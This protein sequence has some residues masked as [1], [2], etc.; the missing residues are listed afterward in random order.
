MTTKLAVLINFICTILHIFMF[1]QIIKTSSYDLADSSLHNLPCSVCVLDHCLDDM[2]Y[3][4]NLVVHFLPVLYSTWKLVRMN[5]EHSSTYVY[6][7]CF[8][9]QSP[10]LRNIHFYH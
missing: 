2:R 3:L 5:V 8:L 10:S 6:D 1:P 7:D 9:K 4:P